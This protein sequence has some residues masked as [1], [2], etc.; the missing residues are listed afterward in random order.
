MKTGKVI[1]YGLLGVVIIVGLVWGISYLTVGYNKTAGKALEKSRRNVDTEVFY[2]SQSFID[3][4][5]RDALARY[6][7]YKELGSDAER[8]EMKNIIKLEFANFDEEEH[9]TEP[10]KSFIHDAKYN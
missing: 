8:R 9:L 6:N 3:G 7:E 2:E 5:K 1:G 4:K 10:L